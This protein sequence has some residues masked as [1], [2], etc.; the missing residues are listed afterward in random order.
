[1]LTFSLNPDISKFINVYQNN[2][3]KYGVT[4]AN[5][6]LVSDL[7]NEDLMGP[8]E[9]GCRDVINLKYIQKNDERNKIVDLGTD[10]SDIDNINFSALVPKVDEYEELLD[11]MLAEHLE[12]KLFVEGIIYDASWQYG[13]NLVY[14]LTKPHLFDK[15][16]KVQSFGGSEWG[17]KKKELLVKV[18]TDLGF[19]V[20]DF[21]LDRLAKSLSELA[22][23]YEE[24]LNNYDIKCSTITE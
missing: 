2:V 22:N 14:C 24:E 1:M 10:I 6:I 13:V 9:E 5:D 21:N 20:E 15:T 8:R 16:H 23:K 19:N 17:N 3:D 12:N 11:D 4:V 18:V 7:Y